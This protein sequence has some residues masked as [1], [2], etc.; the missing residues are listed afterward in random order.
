[1]RTGSRLC[2]RTKGDAFSVAGAL[3]ALGVRPRE[4][5]G[6]IVVD[7]HRSWRAAHEVEVSLLA[8]ERDLIR[9]VRRRVDRPKRRRRAFFEDVDDSIALSPTSR[10]SCESIAS[11]PWY[12]TVMPRSLP[13]VAPGLKFITWPEAPDELFDQPTYKLL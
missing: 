11:P 13:L 8:I 6:L 1:M 9:M 5:T 2:G 10:S 12:V 7:V 4:L 3:E